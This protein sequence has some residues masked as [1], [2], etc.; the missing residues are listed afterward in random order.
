MITTMV[1][2]CMVI[3]FNSCKKD[4]PQPADQVKTNFFTID[5][6]TFVTGALPSPSAVGAPTIAEVTGNDMVLEGG[7]N[8]ISITTD[9]TIKEVIIG[10]QGKTGYYKVPA[11]ALKAGTVSYMVYLLFSS[12]FVSNNFTILI[13]IVDNSGNVSAFQTIPVKRIVAGTGK[14]QVN[15]SWDQPNDVDLHLIE[16]GAYE[17]YWDTIPSPSG[18]TLDVDS[19]PTCYLDYI[20]SENITYS[21]NA[22][23]QKGTYMVRIAY[24]KA[25]SVTALTHYVVTARM[26]GILVTPSTGTNPYYGSFTPDQA[27]IDGNGVRDGVTVMEFNVAA[28]KS[29]SAGNQK[30]LQFAYPRKANLIK[31]DIAASK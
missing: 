12:N 5:N 7:S 28:T 19:N 3:V 10:V 4:K 17:V 16:P 2:A 15:V 8:P 21:G 25:C 31:R 29:A 14:L 24:F 18:G 1:T 27:W 22:T 6:A 30:M 20:N 26:D 13:A 9:A 11:S 23:V